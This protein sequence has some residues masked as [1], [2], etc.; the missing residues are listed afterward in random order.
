[1][2]VPDMAGDGGGYAHGCFLSAVQA[3][4]SSNR[5]VQSRLVD[6][7]ND[8]LN[9]IF[10]P[11]H[12]WLTEELRT[13]FTQFRDDVEFLGSRGSGLRELSAHDAGKLAE[14]IVGIF[15]NIALHVGGNYALKKQKL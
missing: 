11:E 3:L 7:W 8:H 6:A 10:S 2:E 5:D 12:H 13:K 14:R 1:V 4:A 15:N 9:K